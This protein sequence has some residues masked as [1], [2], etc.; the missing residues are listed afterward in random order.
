EQAVDLRFD[1]RTALFP[2][3]EFARSVE[4]LRDAERLAQALDD[5]RRLGQVSV[6]MC[7]NLYQT[8]QLKEALAFGARAQT[9][10]ESLQDVRL[11]VTGNL[12][13]GVACVRAGDFQRAE[14]LCLRVLQLL[15]SDRV[16]ERFGLAGLPAVLARGYLTRVHADLGRFDEGF[17]HG[18]EAL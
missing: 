9:L 17:A 13:F 10:A 7:H 6:Y 5:Q 8:G 15:D 18:R 1:L 3:A 2:L 11:Q 12:Y 14:R 16:R 4:C